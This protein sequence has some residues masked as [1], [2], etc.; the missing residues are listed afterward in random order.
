MPPTLRYFTGTSQPIIFDDALQEAVAFGEVHLRPRARFVSGLGLRDSNESVCVEFQCRHNL[1]VLTPL[2]TA[3]VLHSQTGMEPEVVVDTA[4]GVNDWLHGRT[5]SHKE[6]A[7]RPYVFAQ[8]QAPVEL[9]AVDPAVVDDLV[10]VLF[11]Q[12]I[13]LDWVG[14]YRSKNTVELGS[15]PFLDKLAAIYL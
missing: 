4:F 3:R 14:T 8:H 1:N 7:S 15:M 6:D 11:S 5:N 9:M 12:G 2:L 13:E 10:L